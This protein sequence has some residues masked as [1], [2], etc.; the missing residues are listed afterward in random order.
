MRRVFKLFLKLYVLTSTPALTLWLS[1]SFLLPSKWFM[2]DL[3]RPTDPE[4]TTNN[5]VLTRANHTSQLHVIH[6]LVSCSNEYSHYCSR[7]VSSSENQRILWAVD[8]CSSTRAPHHNGQS[9]QRTSV[10]SARFS[11][12]ANKGSSSKRLRRGDDWDNFFCVTWDDHIIEVPFQ[13]A[14]SFIIISSDQRI[15]L[16]HL[17]SKITPDINI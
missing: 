1:V 4:H 3:D 17:S 7:N 6:F 13:E 15:P 5:T 14:I 16:Q 11:Q 12:Y 2:L 9:P 8:V 10:S